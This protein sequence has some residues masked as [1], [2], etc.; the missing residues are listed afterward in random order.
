M[1]EV[2]LVGPGSQVASKENAGMC[3]LDRGDQ[4]PV[5]KLKATIRAF[6]GSRLSLSELG[7]TA[8]LWQIDQGINLDIPGQFVKFGCPNDAVTIEVSSQPAGTPQTDD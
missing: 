6:R 2:L 1:S 7:R 4:C 5:E 8:G 3:A